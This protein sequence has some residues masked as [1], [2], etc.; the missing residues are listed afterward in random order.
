MRIG[1]RARHFDSLDATTQLASDERNATVCCREIFERVDVDGTLP[2]HGVIVT[3]LTLMLFIG[4]IVGV[5]TER[6]DH[7]PANSTS[8]TSTIGI[9]AIVEET[10]ADHLSV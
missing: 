8:I 4:S 3:W 7:A 9:N 5:L 2:G 1:E 10:P 6:V